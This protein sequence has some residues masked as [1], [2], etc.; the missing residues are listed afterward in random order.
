MYIHLYGR[1]MLYMYMH[2]HLE[3]WYMYVGA[4]FAW[5]TRGMIRIS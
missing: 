1:Y 4:S 3:M 5:D 2:L